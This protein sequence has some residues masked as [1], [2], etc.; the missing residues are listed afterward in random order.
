MSK[1]IES[2][3]A[4]L[5]DKIRSRFP[6]IV[7]GDEKA[8]ATSDPEKA[9]FFNFTYVDN[10]VDGLDEDLA[11]EFGSIDSKLD[12]LLNKMPDAKVKPASETGF[13][14]ITISLIDET[15]VKIY[16]AQNITRDMDEDQRKNWYEFL[17]NLRQF[18]KRNL[19]SFDT[20]DI[21][22]SNLD[23]RDI[24]QQ[25]K[26]DDTF[27]AAEA[28][29]TESKLYGTPGRPYNSF[30]DKGKCKI[31]VRHK[32][33]V[34]EEIRGARSRQI[35]SIFLE[36][37]VGERFLLQHTNL[38]GAYALAEHLTQG[39]SLHDEFSNHINN[40]VHEMAAMKHFVRSQKLREF[41]DQETN[42]MTRAA[43][44]HYE[45]LKK[46]LGHLRS[47]RYFKDYKENFVAAN[48]IEE[49]VDVEA[50]KERWVKKVYDSRFDE[51]LPYV[52]RAYKQQQN[53][54]ASK[55]SYEL[56]EWATT[57]LEDMEQ[58][59]S[60]LTDFFAQAQPGGIN[61]IDATST[62]EKLIPNQDSLQRLVQNYASERGQGPDADVRGIV[63][64]WIE[65]N[66]PE[67]LADIVMPE[68][69]Y[70]QDQNNFTAPVSP[71][72]PNNANQTGATTMDEPVVN[73]ND[74]LSFIRRLAGL[75]K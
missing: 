33:K 19:L 69:S 39:G 43:V 45:K 58:A 63:K 18:A 60:S 12:S 30:A 15:S 3:A 50:L 62:L 27:S 47:E 74:S 67:L 59:P 35:E 20:R 57:M 4:A 55:L 51:A 21:T 73:E 5:F 75:A 31:L 72:A 44:T 10:K 68:P 9:R 22:K 40:M 66:Q 53:E 64:T 71:E 37:D 54:A 42:D 26:T 36:T 8:N 14:K 2:V 16:F 23:I 28:P 13:G 52:Y 41:E 1:E 11:G 49:D 17:R 38:N 6:N 32:N 7:L 46:T 48:D 25:A 70:A 56:D 24:K 29:V 34:D 65:Q 61:G